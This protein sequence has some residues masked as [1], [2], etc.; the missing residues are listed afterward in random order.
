MDRPLGEACGNALEV[1]EALEGLR[2]NGPADLMEV[3]YALGVEMLRVGG[4]EMDRAAA[5]ARLEEIVR[6]GRALETFRALI[7]E[8]G[9]DSAVV[10][11]DR[12]L[13][14]A[15]IVADY[16]AA[17]DGI[18]VEVAPRRVGHAI[19]AL[20]GGR[21]RAEDTVDPSVGFVIR[22]KPGDRVRKGETLA[23][24]H[25]RDENGLAIARQALDEAIRIGH[26]AEP[27]P[28]VSHRVSAAG[29]E[30]L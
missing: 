16:Q 24:I 18:V 3:T 22:A 14:A 4:I 23:Q 2:G 30:Q 15:P 6:S 7:A 12:R 10:D 26:S 19:I 27:R 28:L 8:Q 20:G 29:V 9:G 1:R 17:A 13:P 25:A 11:D 21:N 5:R